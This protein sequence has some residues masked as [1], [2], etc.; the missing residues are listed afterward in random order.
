MNSSNV[1]VWVALV[2]VA[3][4]AAIGW[5]TPGAKDVAPE[6]VRATVYEVMGDA[7][8]QMFGAS[9]SRFPNGLSADSTSPVQGELRGTDLTIT[10]DAVISGGSV[11]ITTSNTATSTLQVGCIQMTAT[12]TANPIKLVPATYA[13]TTLTFGGATNGLPVVAVY[14]TCP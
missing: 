9:G 7:L 3:I 12:T 6:S 4:I 14:G 8:E 5:T 1:F 11:V 2:A 10:D 13:T